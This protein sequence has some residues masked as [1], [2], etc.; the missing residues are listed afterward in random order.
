[1]RLVPLP[2]NQPP[3]AL[4]NRSAV[5][6]CE[7]LSV[8][9]PLLVSAPFK[10][11]VPPVVGVSE[12]PLKIPTTPVRL[13]VPPSVPPVSTVSEPLPVPEPVVLFASNVPELT[14]VPPP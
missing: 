13:P 7:P 12:P 6:S 4:V 3:L 2:R 5:T 9:V 1:M 10:V 8:T 14:T 11:S